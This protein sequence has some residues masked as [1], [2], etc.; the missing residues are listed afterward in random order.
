MARW[1]DMGPAQ[2]ARIEKAENAKRDAELRANAGELWA[3]LLRRIKRNADN[4]EGRAISL[5]LYEF[6]REELMREFKELR[7][8]CKKAGAAVPSAAEIKAALT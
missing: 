8:G 5:R 2:R 6:R 7:V 4:R 1:I 3:D